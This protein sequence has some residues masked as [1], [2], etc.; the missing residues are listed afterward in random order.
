MLDLLSDVESLCETYDIEE[1]IIAGSLIKHHHGKIS[2]NSN[3]P[4]NQLPS[5]FESDDSELEDMLD[6]ILERGRNLL[7]KTPKGALLV[8]TG[9]CAMDSRL[10]MGVETLAEITLRRLVMLS[11]HNLSHNVTTAVPAE[12]NEHEI[13]PWPAGQWQIRQFPH[14]S[15]IDM[16]DSCFDQLFEEIG[17]QNSSHIEHILQLWLTLNCSSSDDKFNPSIMPFIG[18]SPESVRH[19]IS[20]IAWNP[21]LSLRTWCCAL[22]MLTLICNQTHSGAEWSNDYGIYSLISHMIGHPDFV[23]LLLRLLSG[24][25]VVFLDKGLVNIFF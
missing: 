17:M 1:N 13:P 16:L 23:Q 19:L 25:G 18:L 10:E 22:Q 15:N 9:S 2:S 24:T 8:Y 4:S 7:K 5:V 20:A 6:D 21:G 14:K 11:T 12:E 3:N